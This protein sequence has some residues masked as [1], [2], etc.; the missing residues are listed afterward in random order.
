[1]VCNKKLVWFSVGS[2]EINV[3]LGL[4]PDIIFFEVDFFTRNTYQ[5]EQRINSLTR[6]IDN[7][8]WIFEAPEKLN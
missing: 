2:L 4:G 8:S 1:M 3:P 6:F 7:N 5:L